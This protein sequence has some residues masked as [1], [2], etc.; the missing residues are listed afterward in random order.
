MSGVPFWASHLREDPDG[1]VFEVDWSGVRATV[2]ALDLRQRLECAR[3]IQYLREDAT[4]INPRVRRVRDDSYV[5]FYRG[6]IL[7]YDLDYEARRVVLTGIRM[8]SS[9]A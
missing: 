1:D 3:A 7:R 8:I 2:A 4:L 9:D 5:L 6:V